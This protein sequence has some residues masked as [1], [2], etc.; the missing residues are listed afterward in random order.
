[1][2]TALSWFGRFRVRVAI[3]A[4]CATVINSKSMGDLERALHGRQ[5]R[6]IRDA[7]LVDH[8]R[9]FFLRHAEQLLE[10]AVV[11]LTEGRT[12]EL[13]VLAPRVA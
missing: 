7:V 8:F 4:S 2:L 6:R 13:A 1:M 9:H 3:P 12:R 11:V 10:Y 5:I